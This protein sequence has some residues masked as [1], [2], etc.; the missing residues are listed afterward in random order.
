MMNRA[1]D[2]INV[3][4]FCF[5]FYFRQGAYFVMVDL[6]FS[7][8]NITRKVGRDFLWIDDR[9]DKLKEYWIVENLN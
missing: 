2:Y 6:C 7:V 8:I 5:Y 4:S 9:T 3:E 1:Y